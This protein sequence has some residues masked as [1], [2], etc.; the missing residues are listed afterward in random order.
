MGDSEEPD[1]EANEPHEGPDYRSLLDPDTDPAELLPNLQPIRLLDRNGQLGEHEAYPLDLKDED[2]R[3]LYRHMV[4]A[5]RVDR[6]AINLQRQGQLGVYASC[7]GQEAAQVGSAYA[8]ADQDWIFPSYRELAAGIVRGIDTAGMLQLYRGTWLSDY[9]P[10]EF[11]FALMAIPISTQCLHAAGFAM[12]ARLAGEPVVTL[13]YFGDGATSEGDFHEASNFAA[14]FQAPCVFFC[15]NNQYAISVPLSKQTHA[16]SIAH[17]GV[18][19][20]MPGRRVDGND[21]LA[22]YAVTKWA[23]ERARRGEGPTLIE[24]LTYRMEAHTT[25]DDP[26]RYRTREELDYWATFDPIARMEKFLKGRDLW[27]DR[28][29]AAVEDEAREQSGHVRDQIYDAPHPDPEELFAHVYVEPPPHLERQRRQLQAELAGGGEPAPG[30]G[31]LE[32][33]VDAQRREV[34]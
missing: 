7:L 1:R 3:T 6:E 27:E 29:A 5:R 18:G 14:V 23:S 21:V 19:Y 24:A 31:D 33:L 12:G 25:S 15:Q 10:Y 32:G 8:L 17:K 30:G 2:L 20:G 4:V 34:L 22:S 16:P 28:F 26:T 13:V 11:H 9:D